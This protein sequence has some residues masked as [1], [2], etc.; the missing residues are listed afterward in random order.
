MHGRHDL[1]EHRGRLQ[2]GPHCGQHFPE[3]D[4]S[5]RDGDWNHQGSQVSHGRRGSRRP[6][7]YRH[8]QTAGVDEDDG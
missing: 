7:S 5:G 6:S 8:D 1:D 2:I 3:I 4:S